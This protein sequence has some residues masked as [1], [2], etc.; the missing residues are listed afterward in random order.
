MSAESS[1][2]AVHHLAQT[3]EAAMFERL[4][5]S[6]LSPPGNGTWAWRRPAR[7]SCGA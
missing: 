4:S 3:D 5:R 6:N 2:A 1:R 7:S